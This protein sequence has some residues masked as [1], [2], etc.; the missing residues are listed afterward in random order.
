MSKPVLYTITVT[1]NGC[2]NTYTATVKEPTALTLSKTLIE[3]NKREF[4]CGSSGSVQQAEI[5][6]PSGAVQGGTSPYR[7][8]YLYGT[9][10]GTG[11]S[12]SI[13]NTAGG[14]VTITAIDANGCSTQTSVVIKPFEAFD[15]DKIDFAV[16]ATGTCNASETIT[17]N[18]K[19]SSGAP[20]TG[21][22]LYYQGATA[23]AGTLT[24]TAGGWQTSNSFTIAPNRTYTFWVANRATGCIASKLYISPNPNNFSIVNPQ[25]KNVGCKGANNGTATF[26][27]SNTVNGHAYNVTLSP[28]AGTITPAAPFTATGTTA[29]FNIAGLAPN[30]YTVTVKDNNTACEQTY[31]F[32]IE[33]PTAVITASV[34]VH[35]ATCASAPTYNSGEIAIENV[36]GGWGTY[37]YYIGQAAAGLE[38]WTNTSV[39]TGL[40]P[41][42]YRVLVKDNNG[43]ATTLSNTVTIAT[44]TTISGTLTVTHA[45]CT[46]GTGAI[47]VRSVTGGE[48]ANYLYQ[49]IKDGVAQGGAQTSTEFQKL[50]LQ[51]ITK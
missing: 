42:T 6:V 50:K 19:Q 4:S 21:Q 39:R 27:L 23:P 43:C 33:E 37:Q 8:E 3:N 18:A 48:G 20:F 12:F 17:I 24:P 49:L 45:N 9:V 5:T 32:K 1:A 15:V 41:G 51:V 29:T 35:Q 34:T 25:V 2:Q 10:S 14:I 31:S 13:G 30:T 47:G 26:T 11:N 28:S 36:T 7:I 46:N 44:P 16:T 38:V 22:L 40:T